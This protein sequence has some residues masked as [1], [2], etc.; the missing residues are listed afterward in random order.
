MTSAQ[1]KHIINSKGYVMNQW[2]TLEQFHR[3]GLLGDMTYYM[4][5]LSAQFYFDSTSEMMYVR[6]TNDSLKRKLASASDTLYGEEVC[7]TLENGKSFAV[8][9][10]PKG[11]EDN[12]GKIHD[13][14]CF[15]NIVGFY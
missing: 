6:L 8:K 12:I 4:N 5:P 13:V 15:D 9:T 3:V 1:I 7:V 14:V 2:Q 10:L 11:F